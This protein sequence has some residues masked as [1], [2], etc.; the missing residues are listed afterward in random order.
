LSITGVNEMPRGWLSVAGVVLV[1]VGAGVL[2]SSAAA[3]DPS[4]LYV[5]NEAGANCS[6]SGGGTASQPY[7]TLAAA[8][9][10]VSPGQTVEVTS[11]IYPEH[12]TITKSG[13]PGAPIVFRAAVGFRVLLTGPDA[14]ITIAGQH[15]VT[16]RDFAVSQSTTG[17]GIAVSQS[18]RITLLQ[19]VSQP[20]AAG[21][22][23]IVLSAVTDST[24]TSVVAIARGAT[25]VVLDEATS[26]VTATGLTVLDN[27]TLGTAEDGVDILGPDNALLRS[28]LRLNTGAGVYVGP[29]ARRTVLAGNQV[30]GNHGFGV[31]VSA[32]TGVAITN[33]TVVDNCFGG[34][35]MRDGASGASVQNNIV[36]LDGWESNQTQCIPA[37]PVGIGLYD[38][39]VTSSTVDYNL[40]HETAASDFDYAWG[41][42][43]HTLADFRTLSGQG[44]HDIDADPQFVSGHIVVAL[45]SPAIDSANSAAPGWQPLD[46]VGVPRKDNPDVPDTGAGPVPFADRGAQEGNL[47]PQAAQTVTIHPGDPVAGWPV[48]ADAS[49]SSP[50]WSTIASYFFNFGDGTTVTSS[51]PVVEHTYRVAGRYGASVTPTNADGQAGTAANSTVIVGDLFQSAGPVRL[52]DTR[53]ATGVSTTVPVAAKATVQLRV[54]GVAGIPATGV[55]AVVLNTTV[56]APTASGFLTVY[57]DGSALPT[58]SNLNWTA[59]A[60]VA[61]LVT[62]PVVNGV[63]DFYNGSTGTVH[64]IADLAGYYAHSTGL[65]FNAVTPVRVLDTRSGVG[66]PKAAVPAHGT[67]T[68][69]PG[70]AG[71]A[72]PVVLNVT[73]TG[74]KA[75]GF[76]TVYPHGQPRPLAS[77]LNWSTGQTVANAVIVAAGD[78]SVSIYNGSGATVQ[79]VV[80]R[81]GEFGPGARGVGSPFIPAGPVRLLDTRTGTKPVAVAPQGTVALT[82]TPGTNGV[83]ANGLDAVLLNVTVTGGTADGFLTVYPAVDS[84][85]VASNLNWRAGRTAANLVHASIGLDNTILFFNGSTGTVHVVVDLFGW[86]PS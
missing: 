4:V 1:A 8:D 21:Q 80:D 19:D 9:A 51:T 71:G 85:P 83:P 7:C 32:A 36:A 29:Q 27:G 26:G 2:T 23:A 40:V 53:S 14:G 25:G 12:L 30:Q 82:L 34:I 72:V 18:A 50:G 75:N 13:T 38:T 20:Q 11:G 44:Q 86:Y 60:T 43:V 52:L 17:T 41:T 74:G 67:L 64:I 24:L 15:D 49:A 46:L 56:T 62:V 79:V 48:T 35:R 61:N 78:G 73:V 66:A 16:V 58:A 81:N 10:A 57:P 47:L 69:N 37:L 76:L 31:D 22:S 33:N 84:R 39:S 45:S 54:S 5:D 65:P 70:A 59:G 77:S 63:V 55:S 3:A 68:L 6:D 42:P 28:R